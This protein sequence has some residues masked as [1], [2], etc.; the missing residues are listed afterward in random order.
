MKRIYLTENEYKLGDKTFKYK[1]AIVKES[2]LESVLSD[3]FTFG[4]LVLSFALNQFFVHSK[5]LTSILIIMFFFILN[6]TKKE[7]ITKEEFLKE[8]E[9]MTEEREQNIK[10]NK[11]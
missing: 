2:L 9:E 3:L 1:G 7:N 10:D 4:C 5:I 8:F 6:S 11:Q